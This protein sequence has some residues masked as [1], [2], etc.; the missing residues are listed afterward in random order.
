[1]SLRSGLLCTIAIGCMIA[2]GCGSTVV[3]KN[4]PTTAKEKQL[5]EAKANGD[6]D[7]SNGGKWAGWRYQGDRKDCRFVLGRRCFKTRK[8]ACAAARCKTRCEVE[9]GGP[10][11]VSCK[12]K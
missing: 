12:A 10:A 7:D 2:L 5:R 3:D 11:T 6:L 4:E 1:M 9:G 8:A